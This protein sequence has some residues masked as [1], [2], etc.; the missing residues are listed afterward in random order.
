M[1]ELPDDAALT[2]LL[3][4]WDVPALAPDFAARVTAEAARSDRPRLPPRVSPRGRARPWTRRG[5]WTG[6][7]AINIVLASAVAAF[8]GGGMD[9]H[10]LHAAAAQLIAQVLPRHR[11]DHTSPLNHPRGVLRALPVT[12]AVPAMLPLAFRPPPVRRPAIGRPAALHPP[13][14]RMHRLERPFAAHRR[15]L[16]RPGFVR[17]PGSRFGRRGDG[18]NHPH[19]LRRQ[20]G[21]F[22]AGRHDMRPAGDAL[23]WRGGDAHGRQD[24]GHVGGLF[25]VAHIGLADG[26]LAK[27][28]EL[29]FQHAR[30]L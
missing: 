1:T 16:R 22:D 2:R 5:V 26:Q 3:D 15:E 8:G 9:L 28:D 11:L 24:V 13:P 23:P 14:S 18:I 12:R 17:Y 20:L 21:S 10:R 6:I 7:V 30:S 4:A 29:Q 25:A 27:L 19:H